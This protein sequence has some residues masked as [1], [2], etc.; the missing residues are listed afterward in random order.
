MISDLTPIGKLADKADKIRLNRLKANIKHA[1]NFCRCEVCQPDSGRDLDV[2]YSMENK[3]GHEMNALE[4]LFKE[5][6]GKKEGHDILY[7]SFFRDSNFVNDNPKTEPDDAI[8]KEDVR[9]A[10]LD[11][12]DELDKKADDELCN[13]AVAGVQVS[14][15]LVSIA[16][17][18]REVVGE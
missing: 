8:L 4:K 5:K 11:F 6:K 2:M 1:K 15:S 12:A 18:I 9:K 17:E 7:Y 13:R 3:G 10:L 16:A 14:G